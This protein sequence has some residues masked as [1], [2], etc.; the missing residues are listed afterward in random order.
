MKAVY[1]FGGFLI[2][3]GAAVFVGIIAWGMYQRIKIV[4]N[5]KKGSR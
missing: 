5:K 2:V 4:N 1:I 3:V